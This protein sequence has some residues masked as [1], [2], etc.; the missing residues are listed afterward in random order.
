MHT[1]PNHTNG[2]KKFQ[3]IVKNG[4]YA[5]YDYMIFTKNKDILC[6]QK[7][8]PLYILVLL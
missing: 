8:K 4:Q 5:V 3:L 1:H 6:L 2:K 7:C